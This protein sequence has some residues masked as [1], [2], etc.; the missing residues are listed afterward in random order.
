MFS[1]HAALTRQGPDMGEGTMIEKLVAEL[2][3]G[4]AIIAELVLGFLTWLLIL[5][6][7]PK[8]KVDFNVLG[9]LVMILLCAGP[10]WFAHR[11]VKARV[12]PGN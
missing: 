3:L 11:Y 12:E 8:D 4:T 5:G 2:K 7:L 6:L 10:Y 1:G 9:S